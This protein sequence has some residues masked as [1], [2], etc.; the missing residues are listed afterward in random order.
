MCWLLINYGLFGFLQFLVYVCKTAALQ[1][2]DQFAY[3]SDLAI[4]MAASPVSYIFVMCLC[5][6]V[7]LYNNLVYFQIPV[8][9]W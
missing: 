1:F 7:L 2:N 3:R 5:N 4:P 9:L 6:S 8:T